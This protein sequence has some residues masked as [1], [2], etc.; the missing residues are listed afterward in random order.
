MSLEGVLPVVIVV[1]RG[2]EVAQRKPEMVS[3]SL[4]VRGMR[5]RNADRPCS[6]ARLS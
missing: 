2:P 5:Q 6:A 3:L 4:A 1:K